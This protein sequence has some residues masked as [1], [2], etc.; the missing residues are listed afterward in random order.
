MSG[1]RLSGKDI[2]FMLGALLVHAEEV[3]LNIEDNT[4][5]TKSKGVPNGWVSGDKGASGDITVDTANLQTILDAAKQAGS[6]SA[7]EPFDFVANGE[8]TTDKLT[9]EAFGCKLRIN[10]LL[11]AQA[12]GGEKL[13]HKLSYD[14][15]SNDFVK[16][17]GVPYIDAKEIQNLI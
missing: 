5:V 3:T 1:Q 15:T 13:T 4:K 16:I 10:D 2:D 12:D 7:L 14:V 9:I 11:N 6:F 17:N 8:G